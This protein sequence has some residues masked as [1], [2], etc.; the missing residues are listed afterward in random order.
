MPGHALHSYFGGAREA[1]TRSQLMVDGVSHREAEIVGLK[2]GF[3]HSSEG[4]VF[5]QQ[6]SRMAFLHPDVVAWAYRGARVDTMLGKL[7][8]CWG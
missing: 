1:A 6:K 4:E 7:C 2:E 8:A 5:V 3:Q